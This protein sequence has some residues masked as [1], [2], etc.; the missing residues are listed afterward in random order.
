M[1]QYISTCSSKILHTE[2]KIIKFSLFLDNQLVNIEY[3]NCSIFFKRLP[4]IISEFSNIIGT[5]DNIQKSI[6]CLNNNFKA[7]LRKKI[8]GN[9]IFID[10]SNKIYARPVH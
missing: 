6:S 10:K 9:K 7:K 1:Q 4:E 5:K 2:N 3:L 8:I